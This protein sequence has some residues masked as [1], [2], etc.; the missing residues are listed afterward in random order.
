MAY[1]YN[2][3]A[4]L[5]TPKYG[6]LGNFRWYDKWRSGE[7]EYDVTNRWGV[8]FDT[9]QGKF[10]FIPEE[11]INS[12]FVEVG[13]NR[14][15]YFKSFLDP[16]FMEQFNQVAQPVDLKGVIDPQSWEYIANERPTTAEKA[17]PWIEGVGYGWS[18]KGVLV[19]ESNVIEWNDQ[20]LLKTNSYELG[21]RVG[22]VNVGAIKGMGQKDGQFVYVPEASGADNAYAF[23]TPA[24]E[25]D[26]Q[27]GWITK[28]GG[29][30]GDIARGIGSIPFLPE[31][32]GLATGN[33]YVYAALKGVQGGVAGVDPLKVGLQVGA[34][35]GAANLL[36]GGTQAPAP[37]SDATYATGAPVLEG[38]TGVLPEAGLLG[39]AQAF[40]IDVGAVQVSPIGTTAPTDLLGTPVDYGLGGVAPG[41][42]LTVPPIDSSVIDLLPAEIPS[43]GLQ[44]PTVPA[45]GEMGGGTGLT[46]GVPGGTIGATGLTPTGAVPVLGDFSSIINQPS[47]LGQDVIGGGTA[48]ITDISVP[49][50]QA[51]YDE[52]AGLSGLAKG[53]G[54]LIDAVAETVA[55]GLGGGIPSVAPTQPTQP[56]Q[57]SG[58]G[59][60]RGVDYS[61]LLALLQSRATV[62]GLLG[63]QFRPQATDLSQLYRNSLLG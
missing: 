56:Q 53:T 4:V 2:P 11:I 34:T 23:I 45:L 55:G 7:D 14:Q 31:I 44:A 51:A 19:P 42:G 29:V 50:D 35:V 32:A 59:T 6:D 18:G 61:G 27:T 1:E 46:V 17:K 5:Q 38:V 41:T 30:L 8:T 20:G 62:P 39:G 10:T 63:V 54:S 52:Y 9:N 37:I 57:M 60:P 36:G 26:L 24:A 58:G 25:N 47:V 13:T 3:N 40:P 33:P 15:R 22:N 16:N 21:K 12:G 49:F 28:K 43:T 48:P